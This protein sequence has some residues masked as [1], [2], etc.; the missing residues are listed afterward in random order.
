MTLKL[1]GMDTKHKE[2]IDAWRQ[3]TELIIR[4]SF[5]LMS[6]GS[7]SVHGNNTN[8]VYKL[9][10]DK[11]KAIAYADELNKNKKSFEM[12]LDL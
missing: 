2:R 5:S 4:K 1:C 8:Y 3:D 9:G 12:C 6:F 11:D 10:L 7:W